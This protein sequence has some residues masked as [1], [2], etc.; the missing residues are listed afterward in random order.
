MSGKVVFEQ[1]MEGLF[2]RGLGSRLSPRCRERLKQAGLDLT[3]RLLPAYPFEVWMECLRIAAEELHPNEPVDDAMFKIGEAFIDG[4]KETF[5]GRAVLGMVR[6]LGP[7]R[8]ILRSTQNF[9][10]GNNYTETKITEVADNRM[11]LWLNEVG[12]YPTFTAGIISAAL[13]ATGTNATVELSGY[14]GRGCT[15]RCSWA[16]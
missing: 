11:D 9:R 2:M 3:S 15:Y 13:R 4:Y 7:R 10:S 16:R 8:T 5:L 12:A 14:D 6:V 1:T